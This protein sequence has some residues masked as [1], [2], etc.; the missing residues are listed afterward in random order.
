MAKLN[1][2]NIRIRN[3]LSYG[4]YDTNVQLDGL[5]PALIIGQIEDQPAKSCGAGKSTITNAII[6]CLFGRLPF[7]QRPADR[8]INKTTGQ[9]CLVT[10][11]TTDNYIITRTR[12]YDGKHDLLIKQPNGDDISDSTNKNAQQHLSKLF[13]LDYD[14]FTASVFFAQFG[15]P[16]MELPS[17][18]RKKALE[19]MLHLNK[20]DH[21]V[22]VAKERIGLLTSSQ[23]KATAE[24]DAQHREAD[25][26]AQQIEDNLQKKQEYEQQR[27]EREE[28]QRQ[29]LG[30]V[31]DQFDER[32][33]QLEEKLRLLKD[34][35][36]QIKTYDLDN[37]RLEWEK[38]S[39]KV[40]KL[41]KAE[42]R[43]R[44][45]EEQ[46][47][48][49]KARKEAN[50]ASQLPPEYFEDKLTELQAQLQQAQEQA[51]KA[52]THNIGAI[53]L[54]WEQHKE[55][56]AKAEEIKQ[57]IAAAQARKSTTELQIND[58]EERIKD[59]SEKAGKICPNCGQKITK[60]HVLKTCKPSREKLDSL[61]K[62][63]E[64]AE[65]NIPTLSNT[66]KLANEQAKRREP[67]HSLAEA[68][69]IN[70]QAETKA[71]AV[72]QLQ[73][74]IRLTEEE[75]DRQQQ[76]EQDTK[77]LTEE[78]QR[79]SK[80][81]KEKLAEIEQK[82]LDLP[83]P[84]VTTKEAEA[85]KAQY[86]S[87]RGEISGA[88]EAIVDL[89][90][91]RQ[92]TKD[93]IRGR[94]AQIQK[95]PNPW[96]AVIDSSKESLEEVRKKNA[97]SSKKIGQFNELIKHTEY[98]RSAYSDRRKI[99]AHILAR[100][101]PYFNER[102]SYY[103][104]AFE[105]SFTLTFTNALQEKSAPW[106]YEMCSGG[107][108]KKIDV[109]LM[110]AIHD[111]HVSIYDQKCNVL[112]FDEVDGRLDADGITKFVEILFNELS[113]DK[114]RTILVISHKDTMQ[115]AFP[116]KILVKKDKMTEDGC[117]RIEEIR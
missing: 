8:V 98:I 41:D 55:L 71:Q 39:Q 64:Q 27:Q 109:A 38:H 62:D 115:D 97:D 36:K 56:L 54:Q 67:E 51:N 31:D 61:K 34:Q 86:D 26:I 102:I 45:I 83:S 28:Q 12:N 4:D 18:K 44:Q 16:F 32:K 108:R 80:F 100:L 88:E 99:K 76:I 87:K 79:K 57:Q 24:A 30:K 101:I 43:I 1:I 10:I 90:V 75:K 68:Q 11:A 66:L 114:T 21:Y 60:S 107:E 72:K 48:R 53:N 77:Q 81:T 9:N 93:G 23:D 74:T 3:F 69:L 14:I 111:L 106:P 59:M 94:I 91:Q 15:V 49:L 19:R 113:Q 85:Y 95:E 110:F 22:D 20:F 89:T 37:L 42:S 58:E 82:R 73:E 5:G 52:T 6:W 7:K 112:V 96:Q 47:V 2:S 65:A 117:S 63:L 33:I 17:P 13:D 35:L 78:I 104:D 116:T 70:E 25:R 92:Q 84:E 50:E 105:C 40:D 46:V 103:L 29:A